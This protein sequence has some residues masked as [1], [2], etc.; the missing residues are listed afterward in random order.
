VKGLDADRQ[1][2]KRY[3]EDEKQEKK[4]AEQG[5]KEEKQRF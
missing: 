3:I 2:R 1:G 5:N 4:G